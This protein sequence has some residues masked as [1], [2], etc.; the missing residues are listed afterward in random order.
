MDNTNKSARE[1]TRERSERDTLDRIDNLTKDMRALGYEI[2]F[3]HIGKKTTYC[4]MV[5]GDEEIVGYTFIRNLKYLN[6]NVG[7]LKALQQAIARKE[8]LDQ[9]AAANEKSSEDNA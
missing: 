6:E 7:M 2:T 8:V 9:K 5:K 1:F 3:G 4:M